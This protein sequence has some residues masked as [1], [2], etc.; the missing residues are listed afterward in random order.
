MGG[1]GGGGEE[2][3]EERIVNKGA[4]GRNLF[5]VALLQMRGGWRN[6]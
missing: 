1:K 3:G 6:V 4:F 2:R 5:R